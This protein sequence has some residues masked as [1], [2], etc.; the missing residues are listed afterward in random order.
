MEKEN[1]KK[2]VL[3]IVLLMGLISLVFSDLLSNY[4]LSFLGKVSKIGFANL[5]LIGVLKGILAV[6]SSVDIGVGV[7]MNIGAILKGLCD[8]VDKAFNFFIISNSLIVLQIFL[9]KISKFLIVKILIIV[10][11]VFV[12]VKPVKKIA[13]SMLL[14]L[15]L[16]NPGLSLY[17]YASKFI[18][19]KTIPSAGNEI[20]ERLENIKSNFQKILEV[21]GFFKKVKNV[22]KAILGV[23]SGSLNN[24]VDIILIY[25]VS[26]MVLFLF[27]PGV[28]YYVMYLWVKKILQK[29]MKDCY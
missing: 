14:I 18:Y 28:F 2:N 16:I 10:S 27:L 23:V 22:P 4:A 19:D 9:L 29:G 26:M 11:A 25:F 17:V 15:L 1:L 3:V 21:E 20:G 24:L 7:E 5:A 8:I 12:F 13:F 6:A